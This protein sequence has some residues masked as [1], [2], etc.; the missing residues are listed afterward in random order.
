MLAGLLNQMG[1]CS[2]RTERLLPAAPDNPLG[3]CEHLDMLRINDALLQ[4]R[5]SA[6][7]EP[8]RLPQESWETPEFEDLRSQ[9]REFLARDFRGKSISVYKDPR[10]CLTFGFWADLLPEPRILLSLRSPSAVAASLRRR[11][12]L[13]E[14]YSRWL[15][16]RY[17]QGAL[18]VAGSWL[19]GVVFYETFFSDPVAA[20]APWAPILG[21]ELTSERVRGA[22]AEFVRPEF[23]H[24]PT[25]VKDD[26]DRRYER[27]RL[28]T[29]ELVG[30][31]AALRR[32]IAPL[33]DGIPERPSATAAGFEQLRP[34]TAAWW[35]TQQ[36][37]RARQAD[38]VASAKI[39]DDQQRS[40][41][42]T[43][44]D[45][46]GG[47]TGLAPGWPT[48][49]LAQSLLKKRPITGWPR[50]HDSV[51]DIIFDGVFYRQ[52]NPDVAQA[53]VDPKRH[54]LEFGW[55]EGRNPH[56]LFDTAFYL[57]DNP[58]VRDAGIHPLIHYLEHGWKEGRSPHPLFDVKYYLAS[59]PDLG[60]R[61]PLV[62]YLTIGAKQGLN[63]HPLF[64]GLYY[65]RENPDLHLSKLSP[66]VHYLLIGARRGASPC[67]LISAA[68]IGLQQLFSG[69]DGLPT[70]KAP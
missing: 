46:A 42:G 41:E 23:N 53:G 55:R 59:A 65:A 52:E 9:A 21:L 38:A 12:G 30:L 26:L 66:L 17:V 58:D 68:H 47:R 63:P 35:L 18:D 22:L 49:R 2:G 36:S 29:Q 60:G 34:Q 24:G 51:E 25:A 32:I 33:L 54:Y 14:Q 11:N 31:G 43:A 20:M 3:Y 15:W 50:R 61:S 5:D 39:T 62:H 37:L 40:T 19:A 27:L 16:A 1:G 56:P 8:P 6:W 67:P 69:N 48:L 13:D 7:A 70:K 44:Q 28:G 45:G 57:S 64:D 4:R 10:L